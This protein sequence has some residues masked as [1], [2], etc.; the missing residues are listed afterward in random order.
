MSSNR[1]LLIIV[2]IMSLSIGCA[3]SKEGYISAHIELNPKIKEA[4]IK[5]EV[6][7]GMTED[8]VRASWGSPSQVVKGT[9]GD[10]YYVYVK[11]GSRGTHSH[12]VVVF[13]KNGRV[14]SSGPR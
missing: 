1:I 2:L 8:E 7:E 10:F 14:I 3:V 4:I 13:D 5:G 6:L 9:E 11:R 12:E